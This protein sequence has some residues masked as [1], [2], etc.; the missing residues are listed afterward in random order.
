MTAWSPKQIF[1]VGSQ[2][3]FVPLLLVTSLVLSLRSKFFWRHSAISVGVQSAKGSTV[4]SQAAD[5]GRSAKAVVS[6]EID[7]SCKLAK[8]EVLILIH[9][10][11]Q[12]IGFNLLASLV[13]LGHGA[14]AGRKQDHCH[15]P[16]G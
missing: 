10:R 8:V 7:E 3:S 11:L 2:D 16:S 1:N 6:I 12:K 4:H 15:N 13:C 14:K 9:V 5:S